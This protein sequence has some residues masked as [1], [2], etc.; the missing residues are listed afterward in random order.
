MPPTVRAEGITERVGD[1]VL[2][3]TGGTP[4]PAGQSVPQA[5]ITVFLSAN[6]TS[7]LTA[8]P[9]S[10]A[11]LLVDEP[12]SAANPSVPLSPC[13]PA[14]ATLGVCPLSG[15][16]TPGVGTYNPA[17]GGNGGVLRPNVFQARQTGSG[18]VA[19]FGVP[20]DPP[21]TATVRTLRITNLRANASQLGVS[22]TLI[23]T[24][25]TG[26]LS[27]SPSNLLPLNNP[28]QT[29][30]FVS[31]GLAA[32]VRNTLVLPQCG[33]AESTL[34]D[35]RVD[36]G[37]PSAWKEK[38]IAT[39]LANNPFFF[40]GYPPDAAQDVPGSNY[41]SESGFEVN[42]VTPGTPPAGYGPFG[43]AAGLPANP[44]FPAVRGL[45]L[46]GVAHSGTRIVLR[47]S[48]IPAG[49]SLFVPATVNL[50]NPLTGLNSGVAVLV[51]TDANGGGAFASA[52]SGSLPSSGGTAAAV[53]EIVYADPFALER[54]TVPVNV[55]YGGDPASNLPT[56]GVQGTMAA[57]F[58]PGSS[59]AT[60]SGTAPVPRFV[61]GG[62]QMNAFSFVKCTCNI[63]FPFVSNR[64][65]FDTGIAIANTS[66]DPFGTAPHP[67]LITLNY[68]S[69]GAATRVQT[70]NAAVPPGGVLAF[71]LSGGGA[72]GIPG[73]PGFQ[74][75]I[76]AQT[77]FRYCHGFAYLSGQGAPSAG[78]G[79][80]GIILDSPGLQRTGTVGES[81]AH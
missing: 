52:E 12:H 51:N 75:Y 76:I 45:N 53:Y 55:S 61:P 54:I 6:L 40:A 58:A 38:N 43:A 19:F 32:S 29:V 13:D 2:N 47:F 79:Y 71:T 22:A 64:S 23:P 50:T 36:E 67:G 56:P 28:Q 8:D 49:A 62:T 30:A 24:Q 17:V 41:F 63:L 46:A 39:H 72:F 31:P 73:A 65:G 44:A 42:G 27:V 7:R 78:E 35:V 59:V 37:F 16:P 10:E 11:L 3:C 69:A 66:A 33:P 77:Q 57:G 18:Q 5:N 68:Y 20:I 14:G 1:I 21:G 4:T 25:I 74:G 34:F 9:F 15:S 70:T 60:A 81:L 26:Y 48:S 80:L